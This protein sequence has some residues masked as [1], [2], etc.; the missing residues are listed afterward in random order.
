MRRIVIALLTISV[1]LIA[2]HTENLYAQE[3]AKPEWKYVSLSLGPHGERDEIYYDTKNITQTAEGFTQ[4]RLKYLGLYD[5]EQEKQKRIERMKRNREL[6]GFP[7]DEYDRFAYSVM[8]IEIDCKKGLRRYPG[9][10]DFD[11]SDKR[12]GSQYIEG[13]RWEE[14]PVPSVAKIVSDSVCGS[15]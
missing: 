7:L 15:K 11:G 1:F 3:L 2:K 12:I 5:D 4:V 14:I 10:I 8:I 9:I 6:N 13:Q